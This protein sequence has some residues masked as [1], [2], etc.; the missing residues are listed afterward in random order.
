MAI[1]YI[2]YSSPY[3]VF[4][5]EGSSQLHYGSWQGS[6]EHAWEPVDA[7]HLFKCQSVR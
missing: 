2:D 7:G 1:L 3:N 6:N 4:F 5:Y